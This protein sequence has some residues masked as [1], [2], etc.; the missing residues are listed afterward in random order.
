M[1]LQKRQSVIAEE[2]VAEVRSCMVQASLTYPQSGETGLGRHLRHLRLFSERSHLFMV[3]EF[4]QLMGKIFEI[5]F[6]IL[7]CL[8]DWA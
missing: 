3:D 5:N 4:I 7:D 1:I 2:I 8:I 6:N